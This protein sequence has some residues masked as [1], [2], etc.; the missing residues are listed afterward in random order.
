M[1]REKK[2]PSAIRAFRESTLFLAVLGSLFAAGLALGQGSRPNIGYPRLLQAGS[3][4]WI[5]WGNSG[6]T[7]I[8]TARLVK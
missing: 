5:A 2:F 1:I 4:T 6:N 7:K 3:E 8:Q